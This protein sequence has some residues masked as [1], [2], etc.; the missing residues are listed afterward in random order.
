MKKTLLGIV[1]GLFFFL[2]TNAHS[3]QWIVYNTSNSGLPVDRVWQIAIDSENNKWI[4]TDWSGLALL[5]GSTWTVY[6]PSNSGIPHWEVYSVAVDESD[7]VWL[8][9]LGQYGLTRYSDGIWTVYDSLA[10]AEK[11]VTA[12]NTVW[13]GS[14][15]GLMKLDESGWA[16]FDTSNSDIPSNYVRGLAIDSAG[17]LWFLSGS[18]LVSLTG[19]VFQFI[20][21]PISF[22]TDLA[23]APNGTHWISSYLGSI[24]SYDGQFW[25]VYD[26][27][28]QVPMGSI[29]T[30]VVDAA[31]LVWLGADP[32]GLA[33][34]DGQ[35]WEHYTPENS[36]LPVSC[37]YDITFDTLG[38]AWIST[39]GGGVAVF[40]S[41]GVVTQV[42]DLRDITKPDRLFLF[43]NFPNPFNPSTTIEFQLDA[44]SKVR[45]EVYDVLGRFVRV[46]VDDSRGAGQWSASWDGKDR[47]GR[48]AASG[49][50]FYRLITDRATVQKKMLLVK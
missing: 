2:N 44:P 40:N 29:E 43:Q 38:N 11:M 20:T 4:G 48:P 19:S 46:L 8:G 31:G 12:G 15:R 16:V 27:S 14:G 23:I 5:S 45:L 26:S 49:L 35:N 28:G 22:L 39:M 50:Y 34:F 36:G 30:I 32:G 18:S 37:V 25:A 13:A 9:F 3:Q 21:P 6:D 33:T 1:L 42:A 17:V 41:G 10:G 47:Q 24:A 7:A